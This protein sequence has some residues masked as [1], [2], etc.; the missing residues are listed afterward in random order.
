MIECA[1]VTG[2]PA[3]VIGMHFFNPAP[4][5]SLVEVVSTVA[6]SSEVAETVRAVC[7]RLGKHAVSCGDRAGFIV[8]ALLFPYLNDAVK[9]LEAHYATADDIDTAMKEG[10]RLP[11]GPFELLDVIGNDVSLAIERTLY[12]EFREPG[13]APA[14]LLEHLVTAGYLGRKTGRGFRDHRR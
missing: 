14:P 9:M 3:D 8:N 1:A 4:Q 11:M 2:R 6:T 13:F 12:L 5:M 10:C 7:A